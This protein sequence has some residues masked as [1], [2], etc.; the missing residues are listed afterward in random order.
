MKDKRPEI[1]LAI[2][3]IALIMCYGLSLLI[4]PIYGLITSLIFQ[5]TSYTFVILSYKFSFPF[6]Y[7]EFLRNLISK[8]EKR[9]FQYSDFSVIKSDLSHTYHVKLNNSKS[10]LVLIKGEPKL[11][12]NMKTEFEDW[13]VA[14]Y[15]AQMFIKYQ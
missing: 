3:F 13:V 9:I 7:K 10:Y 1:M 4:E 5:I 2:A 15:Y 6:R 11:S 14:D 8:K 12:S